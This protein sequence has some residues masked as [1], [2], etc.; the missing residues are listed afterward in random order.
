MEITEPIA[1]RHQFER[2]EGVYISHIEAGSSAQHS[3]L[4]AG[5]ILIAAEGQ[6]VKNAEDVK[7]IFSQEKAN[8]L[9]QVMR[10]RSQYYVIVKK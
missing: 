1:D 10:G 6:Q 7:R 9:L 8:Y 4:I 5:D 3:G 2:I